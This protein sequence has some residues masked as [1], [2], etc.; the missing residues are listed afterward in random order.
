[1]YLVE[2]ARGI[3]NL[4]AVMLLCFSL[5]PCAAETLRWAILGDAGSRPQKIADLVFTRLSANEDIELVERDL[6]SEIARERELNLVFNAQSVADRVKLLELMKADRLVC[7]SERSDSSPPTLHVVVAESAQG[8]RLAA[9][10]FPMDSEQAVVGQVVD[11]I[12]HCSRHYAKGVKAVVGVAPFTPG[13]LE[14]DYD[15]LS[16]TYRD[17]LQ[18]KLSLLPGV[19]VIEMDEARAIAAEIAIGGSKVKSRITPI[20]ID[21][22][23]EV[24]QDG[25]SVAFDVRGTQGETVVVSVQETVARVEVPSFFSKRLLTP[26]LKEYVERTTVPVD[27]QFRWLVTQ[28]ESFSRLALPVQSAG[29]REAALLLKP[30]HVQERL[31]LLADYRKIIGRRGYLSKQDVREYSEVAHNDVVARHVETYVTALHHVEYLIMNRMI[32]RE[33]AA[34]LIAKHAAKTLISPFPYNYSGGINGEPLKRRGAEILIQAE[35]AELEMHKLVMPVFYRLPV[36]TPNRGLGLANFDQYLMLSYLTRVD[37]AGPTP[38][39]LEECLYFFNELCP[40]DRQTSY[41]L[42]RFFGRGRPE[43]DQFAQ[44]T[45][46]E[47]LAFLEKLSRS[48]KALVRAMAEYGRIKAALWRQE[49][50]ESHRED[51]A[52]RVRTL[53]T[54]WRTL[55]VKQSRGRND[56]PIF[57]DLKRLHEK[58]AP[59]EKVVVPKPMYPTKPDTWQTDPATWRYWGYPEM[60]GHL[61]FKQLGV[62]M[63]GEHGTTAY[64]PKLSFTRGNKDEDFLWNQ[65]GVWRLDAELR[66]CRMAE[67]AADPVKNVLWDG[68]YLWIL[69]GKD[70]AKGEHSLAVYDAQGR[71]VAG[72][73]ADDFSKHDKTM[74]MIVIE[75]STVCVTGTFFPHHRTWLAMVS[76]VDG[77][78][79]LNEFH[80]ATEV[81]TIQKDKRSFGNPNLVFF[82]GWMHV[83]NREEGQTPLLLIA[84]NGTTTYERFHPLAIDTET[85]KVTVHPYGLGNRGLDKNYFSTKGELLCDRDFNVTHWAKL[86]EKWDN[87]KEWIHR[88]KNMHNAGHLGDGFFLH[89]GFLHVTGRKW[90]RINL[91]TMEEQEMTRGLIPRQWRMQWYGL[92]ENHGLI[93]FNGEFYSISFADEHLFTQY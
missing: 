46:D 72:L 27:E 34:D 52:A 85:L 73:D 25:A 8:A 14:H 41:N 33:V 23:Y 7:L 56:E 86:G 35:D 13:N 55:P 93:G 26:A 42:E 53:M 62:R 67:D 12:H 71:R 22:H 37:S 82:P 61:R 30:D 57:R 45:S 19:A 89:G 32:D 75:T 5:R 43:S 44:I 83:L 15:S 59:H 2:K 87:G 48:K 70:Y 74:R 60:L 63:E 11:L 31:S 64:P 68:A 88:C 90:F 66:M 78:V 17:L 69:S 49:E 3:G 29:L 38:K 79:E 28:A 36:P 4:A 58:L 65:T 47:W 54:T 40:E 92:S 21:G 39:Q 84:R 80:R 77:E 24:V 91:K 81:P 20:L 76:L 6:L 51:L 18:G 9:R 10:D 50:L 16:T 1:M